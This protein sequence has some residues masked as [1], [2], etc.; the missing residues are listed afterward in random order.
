MAEA[1]EGGRREVSWGESGFI[2]FWCERLLTFFVSTRA[3]ACARPLAQVGLPLA[4]PDTMVWHRQ[5]FFFTGPVNARDAYGHLLADE[6]GFS[7]VALHG[8]YGPKG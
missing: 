2:W 3:R 7:D 5:D 1:T 6:S 4:R 8:A